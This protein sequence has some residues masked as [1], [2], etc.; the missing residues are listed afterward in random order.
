MQWQDGSEKAKHASGSLQASYPQTS[1][2]DLGLLN[3]WHCGRAAGGSVE[4]AVNRFY[5][6]TTAPGSSS[7]RTA[8]QPRSPAPAKAPKRAAAS[9]PAAKAAPAKKRKGAPSNTG[10]SCCVVL[11]Q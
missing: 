11:S 1:V 4:L 3:Q 2:L 10:S 9:K 7:Q 8:P 6:P 5:D